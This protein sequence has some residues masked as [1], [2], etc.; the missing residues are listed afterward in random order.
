MFHHIHHF[1]CIIG[2]SYEKILWC[3]DRG[4]GGEE[5]Q[6]Q[7]EKEREVVVK[8]GMQHLHLRLKERRAIFKF[9]ECLCEVMGLHPK[10]GYTREGANLSYK[11]KLS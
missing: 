9:E 10:G 3:S 11:Y 5:G 2:V 8:G 6:G 4:R 1:R 7:E